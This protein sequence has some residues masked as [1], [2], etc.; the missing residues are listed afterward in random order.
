[1][2]QVV[3]FMFD[4]GALSILGKDGSVDK[5]PAALVAS[6]TVEQP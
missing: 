1:M 3:R 5:Y 2:T 6:V 4:H